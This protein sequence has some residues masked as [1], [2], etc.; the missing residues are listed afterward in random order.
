MPETETIRTRS[1]ESAER[2]YQCVSSKVNYEAKKK[3]EYA[4]FAKS[5]P[6]LI[7]TCGLVESLAFADAKG[8]DDI[9]KD[10]ASVLETSREELLAESRHADVVTYLRLSRETLD[11]AGWIKRYVEALL[12]DKTRPG[13]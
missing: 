8:R 13:A 3:K 6:A 12:D 7:H 1:Q 4:S 10:L 5:F 9:L 2:A 11:A